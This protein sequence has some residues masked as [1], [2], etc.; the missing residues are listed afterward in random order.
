VRYGMAWPGAA[1]HGFIVTWHGET[2]LGLAR[3]GAARHGLNQI[4][5]ECKNE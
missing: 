5:G 3:P 2:G 4:K 1:W